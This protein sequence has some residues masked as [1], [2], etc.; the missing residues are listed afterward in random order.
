MQKNVLATQ[1]K[2]RWAECDPTRPDRTWPTDDSN[3]MCISAFRCCYLVMAGAADSVVFS[4]IHPFFTKWLYCPAACGMSGNHFSIFFGSSRPSLGGWVNAGSSGRRRRRLLPAVNRRP[5]V[6]RMSPA[7]RPWITHRC[8]VPSRPI[9]ADLSPGLACSYSVRPSAEHAIM[10]AADARR[11]ATRESPLPQLTFTVAIGGF[12]HLSRGHN[13]EI[14]SV[15]RILFRAFFTT[16]LY[17]NNQHSVNRFHYRRHFHLYLS[18]CFSVN[19]IAKK[20]LIKS[21][22]NVT[23]CLDITQAPID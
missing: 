8:L 13:V 12:S 1:F 19:R 6:R 16:T 2:K 17:N 11:A 9:Q 7:A 5:S 22:Q 14:R 4:R 10:A 23:E 18:V 21:L 15:T 3:P 20:P